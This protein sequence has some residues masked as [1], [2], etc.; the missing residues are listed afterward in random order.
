MKR[1]AGGMC[2]P[3]AALAACSFA[4]RYEVPATVAVPKEYQGAATWRLAQPRD[5]TPRGRWWTMFHDSGLDVLE[6]KV[7]TANQSVQ[8]AAA[9]LLQARADT[10]VARAAWFPSVVAADSATRARTSQYA[11][12]VA[13]GYPRIGNDLDLEADFSYELDFWG[14]IRNQVAAA[15]AAAEANAA[16]LA[17][18]ELAIRAELANDYFAIR[19]YDEQ[20]VLLDQTAAD[21]AQALQLTQNLFT[22]GAAALTDVAQAQAQLLNAQTQA[23]DARLGRARTEHALA[24]LVG[25]N[26]VAFELAANPLPLDA[27]VPS[28]DPG[29]PSTLLERR[30]DVAAA[31]RRVAASNSQIGVARAAYFPQVIFGAAAGFNSINQSVFLTAPA[32]FWQFG[33]QVTLPLFEGGRLVAQADHA[34]A[35]YAEQAANYRNTVLTA[36]QDVEDNLTALRQLEAESRTLSSAVVATGVVLAQARIRYSEGLVTYLE[37]AASENAALQAQLSA[38]NVQARRLTATV[39]LVK[40]LGGGWGSG[41]PAADQ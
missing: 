33:P 2:L 10:R 5:A 11:P 16:D 12:R 28:I 36:Y 35:V 34:K 7:S 30:P 26:P 20:V 25:E 29:I 1:L 18:I 15:S 6:D 32:R 21:Y 3:I 19:S 38:I 23:A 39:L 4:P 9:R 24:V 37:V 31:E 8:A 41:E 14:R 17:G 27:P 40:A 22:E 13:P